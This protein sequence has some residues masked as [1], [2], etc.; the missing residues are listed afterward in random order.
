MNSFAKQWRDGRFR[1]DKIVKPKFPPICVQ[2]KIPCE[3]GIAEVEVIIDVAHLVQ[4]VSESVAKSQ[5]KKSRAC[6]SQARLIGLQP[7]VVSENGDT[8]LDAA[9]AELRNRFSA[10]G[11]AFLRKRYAHA[12]ADGR[13]MIGL[14]LKRLTLPLFSEQTLEAVVV[15]LLPEHRS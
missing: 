11:L 9:E 4:K 6:F 14:R 2:H 8:K 3:D 13:W 5:N 1:H 10:A 7:Y 12:D 15:T